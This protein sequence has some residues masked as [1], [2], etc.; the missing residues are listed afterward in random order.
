MLHESYL[1]YDRKYI[2]LMTERILWI[3]RLLATETKNE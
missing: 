2:E 1:G 3:T